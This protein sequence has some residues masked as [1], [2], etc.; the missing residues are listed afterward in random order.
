MTQRTHSPGWLLSML[1]VT[2]LATGMAYGW[3]VKNQEEVFGLQKDQVATD[4]SAQEIA[5]SGQSNVFW[6]GEAINFTVQIVNNSGK[7]FKASG[8]A[9]TIA[10]GTTSDPLDGW[11]QYA[12][13]IADAGST[14]IAV[15]LPATG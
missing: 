5:C 12:E 8:Q 11:T 13:K 14:P 7:P 2:L 15:D 9:Q 3:S 10:Y 1:L 4:Y 6:P